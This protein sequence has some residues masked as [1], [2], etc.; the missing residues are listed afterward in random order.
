MQSM[1]SSGSRGRLAALFS[2]QDMSQGAPWRRILEFS[3]P[4]LIGNLAQQ[5]YNTADSVIVG[6]YVGDNALA[7]VG[8]ASPILNLLLALFVGVSTGAGIL[9]SQYFGAKDKERLSGVVGNCL[10]LTLLSS[11]I[12]M[13]IAPFVTRPLLELLNTPASILD[14]CSDYLNIFFLGILGFAAYNILSGVLRGLGDSLSSLVFLI[15]AT[16]LN[17]GLDVWFVAGL[18]MG[19]AGVAL[20]TILAQAISAVLCFLKLIRM[21]DIFVLHARDLRPMKDCVWKIIRLGVPSG[22]T[23]AIFSTAML[24]VQSLTNSFGEAVIACNAIVMRVDG[25]AM[26][27]NFTFGQAMTTYTGQNVGAGRPDRVR[28]GAKQGTL[29]ALGC[30]AALTLCILLFGRSLMAIFTSTASLVEMS[31]HMMSILAVGYIAMAITQSL[32]GVM[33]GAGDTMTPMWISIVTTVV[34][35][36]PIAYGIAYFT[37]SADY[38]VG[39]P[40][41]V[42]I[43][44][45][46]SWVLGALI[47]LAAYRVGRWRKRAQAPV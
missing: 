40:E 4:M 1:S 2:A 22:V 3:L 29:M 21:H 17:I 18:R 11:L 27:P 36:V 34:L 46:A 19:V 31:Y 12:I 24:V 6:I 16:V 7:A 20:A 32:S 37:R 41:S 14:W 42:F 30:A 39:R 23:Q 26:M 25:F 8:S 15:V 13:V 47:T 28:A 35:R 9:V 38:P 45:L 44:L 10:T 5:M 43:S 33:R